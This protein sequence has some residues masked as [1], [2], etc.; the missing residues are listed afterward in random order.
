MAIYDSTP[1]RRLVEVLQDYPHL[2]EAVDR[3]PTS[4]SSDEYGRGW[5]DGLMF[6]LGKARAALREE[7]ERE[8][9][10]T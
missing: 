8:K 5:G 1:L 10:I 3:V 9:E 6:A 2:L 4:D 7:M